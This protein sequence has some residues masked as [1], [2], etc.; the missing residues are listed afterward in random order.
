MLFF[1][2]LFLSAYVKVKYDKNLLNESLIFKYF[3]DKNVKLVEASKK[4]EQRIL[5]LLKHFIDFPLT[6]NDFEYSYTFIC[7]TNS[8]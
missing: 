6:P 1:S 3:P 5:T 7:S 4:Y 2:I 8:P